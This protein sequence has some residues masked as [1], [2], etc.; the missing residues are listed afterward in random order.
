MSTPEYTHRLVFGT[1]FALAILGVAQCL[2]SFWGLWLL[3]FVLFTVLQLATLE[4]CSLV[5]HMGAKQASKAA[6]FFVTALFGL[7]C[8]AFGWV[9]WSQ[10][11]LQSHLALYIG[12]LLFIAIA[13]KRSEKPLLD[14]AAL[15]L[16]SLYLA[17]PLAALYNLISD[18]GH[19]FQ[20]RQWW[21]IYA[22]AVTK[23]TDVGAWFFGKLWGRS[24]LGHISPHKTVEGVWGGLLVG[25]LTGLA[26]TYFHPNRYP[27]AHSLWSS[28]PLHLIVSAI[29]QLG[30]L[31]E[32]LLK[33]I[34]KVR[35]SSSLPGL[36]GALDLLD[37]LLLTAPLLYLWQRL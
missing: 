10:I 18:C 37:S 2:T 25:C 34:V 15:A 24:S 17:L 28:L 22:V 32:S 29:A 23:M 35:H 20:M 26:L 9:H 6:P 30:D 1:L 14:I 8:H 33:R 21:A 16:G 7:S 11:K 31:L 3:A 13:M 27:C 19:D 5:G 12:F 4:F 36:G